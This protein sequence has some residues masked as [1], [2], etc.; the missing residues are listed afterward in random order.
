MGTNG[1]GG[2][3]LGLN[4]RSAV[5]TEVGVGV[6]WA[7]STGTGGGTGAGDSDDPPQEVLQVR[8]PQPTRSARRHKERSRMARVFAN[9]VRG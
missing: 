2:G 5:C 8:G 3:T 4:A 7:C 6:G 1:M 9:S